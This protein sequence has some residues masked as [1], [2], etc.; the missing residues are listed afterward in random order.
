MTLKGCEKLTEVLTGLLVVITGYYAWV[1]HRIL[2]AN[3]KSAQ[4]MDEQ[5]RSQATNEMFVRTFEQVKRL[6]DRDF[7]TLRQYVFEKWD[8]RY[9][10]DSQ[11]KDTMI[12]EFS[13]TMD[14]IGALYCKGYLDKDLLTDLYGGFIVNGSRKI[15]SFVKHVLQKKKVKRYQVY[16]KRMAEEVEQE[17]RRRYPCD[18]WL[19]LAIGDLLD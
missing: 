8:G 1:T 12:R 11:E 7:R 4:S 6:E 16:F 3:G 2:K 5:V 10:T 13:H 18:K 17:Y 15:E 9:P 14:T 19:D